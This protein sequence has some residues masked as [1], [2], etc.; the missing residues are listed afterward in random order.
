MALG[1]QLDPKYKI[2]LLNYF[3]L[4]MYSDEFVFEIENVI[5]FKNLVR[6][7]E[8]NMKGKRKMQAKVLMKEKKNAWMRDFTYHH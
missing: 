5:F 8:T 2:D 6:K 1:I 7:Y 3:L 4:H